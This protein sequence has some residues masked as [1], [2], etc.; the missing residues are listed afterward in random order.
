MQESDAVPYAALAYLVDECN[1]WGHRTDDKRQAM[2]GQHFQ[3]LL[4]P[5]DPQR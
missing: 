3:R 4:Q 1:Y 5:Q 2:P